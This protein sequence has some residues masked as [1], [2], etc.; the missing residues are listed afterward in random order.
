MTFV[1]DKPFSARDDNAGIEIVERYG[2]RDGDYTFPCVF[3]QRDLQFEFE[4]IY[5]DA[6]YLYIAKSGA[7]ETNYLTDAVYIIENSLRVILVLRFEN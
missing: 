3:K 5:S 2:F 7:Q 1:F 4:V 6:P